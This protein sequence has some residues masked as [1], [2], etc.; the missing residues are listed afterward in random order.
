M[1]EDVQLKLV[2][3]ADIEII[4]TLGIETFEET[5]APHN[6]REDMDHYLQEAFSYNRI[7]EEISEPETQYWLAYY[8]HEPAAYSRWCFGRQEPDMDAVNPME[9]HRLYVRAKYK[10]KGIGQL[11]MEAA[12]TAAQK[13]K[14]DRIWLGVW[15]HNT[16]AI[17]FYKKFGF[18]YFGEH[19]FMLGKDRQIDWVMKKELI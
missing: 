17:A 3:H 9:F 11:I 16:A 12:I 14:C 15:E 1:K 4:R 18:E 2:T 8:N 13:N 7:K 10:G 19:E 5:F 6:T